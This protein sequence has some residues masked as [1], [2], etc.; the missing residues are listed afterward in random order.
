MATCGTIGQAAGM[1]AAIA[2]KKNCTPRQVYQQYVPLLQE[3][4]MDDDC[5]LPFHVR[6]TALLDSGATVTADDGDVSKLL[7]GHE[8]EYGDADDGS[9]NAFDAAIGTTV[10]VTLGAPT[11]K[12]ILRIVFDSDINRK[13]YG[14]GVSDYL[15]AYPAYTHI[16]KDLPEMIPPKTITKKFTVKCRI[17]GK[18][19]VFVE[20]TNNYQRLCKLELPDGVTDVQVSFDETWGHD[21]IRLYSLDIYE[22]RL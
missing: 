7:N 12:S 19:Y 18:W 11:K 1:A 9:D 10:N 21:S 14:D 22:R 15:K 16:A 4:L 6:A 17:D 13:T 5:Y 2:L 20:K 8:R 3:M